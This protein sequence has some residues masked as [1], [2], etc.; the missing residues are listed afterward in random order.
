MKVAIFYLFF[1]VA[2]VC[3]IQDIDSEGSIES[4]QSLDARSFEKRGR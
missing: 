4:Q 3:C 2:Q 1:V